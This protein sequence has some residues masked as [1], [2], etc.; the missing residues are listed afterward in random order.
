MRLLHSTRTVEIPEGVSVE[1][2]ARKVR[3]KG[4]RGVLERDMKHLAID[5]FL[6]EEEGKKVGGEGEGRTRVGAAGRAGA[7]A[8]PRPLAAA[9]QLLRVEK[10]FGKRKQLAAIRT[11]SSHVSN[12]IKGVTK[13]ERRERGREGGA[14]WAPRSTPNLTTSASP[15]RL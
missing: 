8:D 9:L 5:M 1:V 11:A 12:L 7:A 13:G 6:I 3:V 4:P 2:K 14:A 10:A 15:S